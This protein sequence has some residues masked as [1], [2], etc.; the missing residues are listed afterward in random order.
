MI[1]EP[2]MTG[3]SGD[4]GTRDVLD[5][6]APPPV[7]VREPR[8]PGARRRWLWALGGALVAS[9]LWGTALMV[10]TPAD[11]TPDLRGYRLDRDPCPDIRLKSVG[12]AIAPREPG[13]SL[14]P[15]MLR[16]GVLDRV[17]CSIMLGE[18][19]SG[20]R[21]DAG[22]SERYAVAVTIALHK[23]TDPRAEFEAARSET[24]LGVDP[25]TEV[26][27]VPDLGDQAYLLSLVDG[28]TELRVLDGGAV[29]SLRLSQFFV[30]DDA[31]GGGGHLT[32][33]DAE[34]LDLSAH[35]PALISD[36]HDLMSSLKH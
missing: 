14:G 5:L 24:D 32:A 16:D 11:R 30:Y 33:D 25:G 17:R 15:G 31:D 9:A 13:G 4:P 18:G 23:K 35:K 8:P 2:E 20:R 21:P 3:E 7:R 6:G 10:Y 27:I 28:E 1:S 19:K 12:E 26:E 34:D 36:M 29:L 22:G